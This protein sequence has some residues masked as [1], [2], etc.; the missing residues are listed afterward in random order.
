MFVISLVRIK[1]VKD[2]LY[3]IE[4]VAIEETSVF[5]RN[6]LFDWDGMST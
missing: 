3:A 1:A 5:P 4:G 2:L 6:A